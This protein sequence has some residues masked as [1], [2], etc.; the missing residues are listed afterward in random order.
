M[1]PVLYTLDASGAPRFWRMETNPADSSQYRTVSGVVGGADV[2]SGWTTA[3]PKN[4]GRANATTSEQQAVL[5]IEAEYKKK[6]DRKYHDSLENVGRHKFFAPMLAHKWAGW[7]GDAVWVQ[8]KLDGF[9][10]VATRD[11]IN[12]RQGKPFHLPH[13]WSALSPLFDDNPDLLLDGEL[14]NHGLRADF[15]TLGSLIRKE[16]RSED[17]DKRARETIQFHIY[18]IPSVP[19]PFSERFLVLRD[20]LSLPYGQPDASSPLS[21]VETFRAMTQEQLDLEYSNFLAVGY[22]GAMIRLNAHYEEGKRSKNLLKR[23]DFLDAEFPLVAV[24]QGQGN[25]DGYA[26]SASIRLPDGRV[27][28]AG[29]SGSQA[30]TRDLLDTWRSYSQ[31]TVRYQALTPDGFLRF[32]VVVAWHQRQRDV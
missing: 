9:R 15:N 16:K 32:P 6:R 12:S 21:V 20:D 23:K 13:I 3:S 19:L 18:D 25:W 17:E 24:E 28:S 27:Q 31:V 8:P 22:E 2:F 30:L 4:V 26:K 29:I 1:F 5:E 10:C 14:Y 11:G 7:T